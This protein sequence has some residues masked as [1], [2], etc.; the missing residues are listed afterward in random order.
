MNTKTIQP[1]RTCAGCRKKHD[2]SDLLA[3]TRLKN[4]E[5]IVNDPY[6]QRGRSVYICRKKECLRKIRD[7][8]G[9]NGLQYGLKVQIPENIW[10]ILEEKTGSANS[11]K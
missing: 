5:V 10:K 2:Q 3:V 9:Q 8:K 11:T 7:R 4:G 6:E 1:Q